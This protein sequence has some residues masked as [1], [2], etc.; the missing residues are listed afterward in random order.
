MSAGFQGRLSSW[1][2]PAPSGGVK[3]ATWSTRLPSGRTAMDG[4]TS[5]SGEH[6]S[7][8]RHVDADGI[9]AGGCS[10][11]HAWAARS[12]RLCTPDPQVQ[13][14]LPDRSLAGCW[15]GLGAACE[16]RIWLWSWNRGVMWPG[17][18]GEPATR[19]VDIPP[20]NRP[21]DA[22]LTAHARIQC[23]RRS[24]S[25]FSVGADAAA[26]ARRTDA[27]FAPGGY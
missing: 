12:A 22:G 5:C 19:L 1:E 20:T 2:A 13:S 27:A 14:Y 8:R 16:G 24:G 25:G 6:S 15:E 9:W 4:T 26:E 17:T 21:R 23:A 11:G 7:A 18:R 3:Q 10:R